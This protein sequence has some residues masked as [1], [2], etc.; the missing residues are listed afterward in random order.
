MGE[1][2][3]GG[4]PEHT[5]EAPPSELWLGCVRAAGLQVAV[6]RG[7]RSIPDLPGPPPAPGCDAELSLRALGRAGRSQLRE[8]KKG[9]FGV[10]K[11]SPLD[12]SIR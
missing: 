7:G 12:K 8:S 1:K 6:G 4:D 3:T 2:G 5:R 9:S 11:G 10:Q